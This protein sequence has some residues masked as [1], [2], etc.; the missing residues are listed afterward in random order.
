MNEAT[1]ENE[2][3]FLKHVLNASQIH[4]TNQWDIPG[5]VRYPDVVEYPNDSLKT[6]CKPVTIFDNMLKSI[7]Y[8]MYKTMKISRGIGL[9]A[10]QIGHNARAI[11]VDFAPYVFINPEIEVI[12]DD[13]STIKE[14]CLSIPYVSHDITRPKAIK[15]TAQDI[16]G[17]TFE[18]TAAGTESHVLQH[19]VDHLNGIVY[20]DHLSP[21]KKRRVMEKYKK[22]KKKRR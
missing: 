21:F 19:E 20:V 3:D 4:I 7:L 2:F 15:V 16:E 9:S 13:E 6:E 5:L 12:D 14:G 17:N 22:I 18:Y 10:N 11:C 8:A 1:V